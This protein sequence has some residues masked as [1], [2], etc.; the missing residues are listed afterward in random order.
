M[1]AVVTVRAYALQ[2]AGLSE[3]EPYPPDYETCIVGARSHHLIE[4]HS[5]FRP[6]SSHQVG[7]ES[8]HQERYQEGCEL[9]IVQERLCA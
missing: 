6:T 8:E 3:Y 7:D 9:V 4:K 1:V 2:S 5:D